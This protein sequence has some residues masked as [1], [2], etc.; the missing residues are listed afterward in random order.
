MARCS[1]HRWKV[2][3]ELLYNENCKMF[4]KQ[5][6]S[7]NDIDKEELL[8]NGGKIPFNDK[9][10]FNADGERVKADET[11]KE[12]AKSARESDLEAQLKAEKE[13]REAAEAKLVGV[14]TKFEEA[15]ANLERE[16]TDMRARLMK[17][18]QD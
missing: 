2:S 15:K 13:R 3:K 18:L 17:T 6:M 7:E 12:G 16:T 14:Q 1:S 9:R 11:P 10:R 4:G 5:V 8:E